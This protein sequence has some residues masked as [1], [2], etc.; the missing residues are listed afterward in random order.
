M[1]L[2]LY[3]A[4]PASRAVFDQADRQLGF[5]LS[6]LCSEGPEDRLT[7]TFNQQPALFVTSI[8]AWRAAQA[9]GWKE[10]EFV[11]GHSLGEFSALVAAGSLAF[12]EGLKLVR[13]RAE[14]MTF[15]RFWT[16]PAILTPR[17][18][19]SIEPSQ[20]LLLPIRIMQISF[21]LFMSKED[22]RLY[23][24]IASIRPWRISERP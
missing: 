24:F 16:S 2:E 3:Q 21:I 5:S 7:D 12:T 14:L 17:L 11:A 10:P 23:K 1:G 8:A 19:K 9:Q 22:R 20:I 6:S 18:Q 15:Y 13:R 4:E